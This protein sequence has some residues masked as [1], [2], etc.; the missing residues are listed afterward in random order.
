MQISRRGR[1]CIEAVPFSR[2]HSSVYALFIMSE[3]FEKNNDGR[4]I[5]GFGTKKK[6]SSLVR[7]R[8]LWFR[9]DC[10]SSR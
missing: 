1:V 7:E 4:T 2:D 9:E 10:L 5:E 6:V 8:H 3:L